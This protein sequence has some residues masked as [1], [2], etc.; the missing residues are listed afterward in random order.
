MTRRTRLGM[1][2]PSSNTVLEPVSSAMLAGLPDVTAHFG[3]FRVTEISLGRQ[4]LGQFDHEPMLEAASLL[5]DAKVQA[6]CWNGTSASWLGLDHD[7]ELCAAIQDRTGIRATSA[8]LALVEIFRLAGVERFG[9]VT[10]YLDE[11][12]ERILPT[13]RA[14]GFDC[15]AERHLN[16]RGNFSFAEHPPATLAAMVREVA[17]AKP[18]AIAILCTNLAGAPLVERLEQ[19]IGIPVYDSVATALWGSL[20]LAGVSPRRVEGWGRLF[21]DLA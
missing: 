16:D 21:R 15:V 7:R 8:V 14:E 17:E 6:I 9:L 11:I 2:T 18:Q 13:F 10:P 20:R 3:R 1:L 19:E 4:A 5:A 12:Q